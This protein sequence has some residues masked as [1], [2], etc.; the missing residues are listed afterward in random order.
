MELIDDMNACSLDVPQF[1]NCKTCNLQLKTVGI[2]NRH[3]QYGHGINK[4]LPVC[5]QRDCKNRPKRNS[6]CGLHCDPPSNIK[7]L[8]LVDCKKIIRMPRIIKVCRRNKKIGN[9]I[10]HL[11]IEA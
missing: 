3:L 6:K 8:G 9:T 10:N 1:Y 7:V 5:K 2:L 4:G 11:P